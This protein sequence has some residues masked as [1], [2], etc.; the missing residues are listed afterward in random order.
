MAINLREMV[1]VLEIKSNNTQ[2]LSIDVVTIRSLF[3][4]NLTLVMVLVC[5][6]LK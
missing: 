1:L 5:N 2:V 4:E 6:P 3:K